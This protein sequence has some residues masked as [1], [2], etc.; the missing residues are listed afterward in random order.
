MITLDKQSDQSWLLNKLSDEAL[1]EGDLEIV[2]KS[3][4]A[5][6]GNEIRIRIFL[7]KIR[8]YPRDIIWKCDDKLFRTLMKRNGAQV[9]KVAEPKFEDK[10][11]LAFE[12]LNI[13]EDKVRII[14][15]SDDYK[16]NSK[17]DETVVLNQDITSLPTTLVRPQISKKGFQDLD[18]WVHKIEN[19]KQALQ[20]LKESKAQISKHNIEVGPVTF[21]V[22]QPRNVYLFAGAFLGLCCIVILIILFPA[23]VYT[24]EI[25]D[26]IKER[27]DTYTIDKKQFS[28]KTFNFSL[29][30]SAAASGTQKLTTERATGSVRLFNSS[31][32]PAKLPSNGQFFLISEGR[33]YAYITGTSSFPEFVIPA[34]NESSDKKFDLKIQGTEK[35]EGYNAD[36]GTSF[37]IVNTLG[38]RVC[39]SCF[40]R[41]ITPI[42]T[43][44]VTGNKLFIEE[45][46]SLLQNN[47][48]AMIDRKKVENI[49]TIRTSSIISDLNWVQNTKSSFVYSNNV[50]DVADDVILD[51]DVSSDI[52]YLTK[53]NVEREIKLSQPDIR[54]IQEITITETSNDFSDPNRE[55]VSFKAL[56]RYTIKSSLDKES[57]S[58]ILK[59]Q[60]DLENIKD[61]IMTNNPSISNISS[62]KLGLDLPL[63]PRRIDVDFVEL[64]TSI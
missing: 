11:D 39:A 21:T 2:L 49:D 51:T 17:A 56:Y 54:S 50:G 1:G 43:T 47:M 57:I 37:I 41:A 58:S 38:Q 9:A 19:T 6:L 30:V 61:E 28:K 48:Q 60:S 18:A 4:P 46:K 33:R 42:S 15:A 8:S 36:E 23:T 27:A 26:I 22:S 52:Y 53:A 3:V 45:D 44:E 62:R 13:H 59:K 16:I 31:S 63:I 64:D 20:S 24:L 29:S 35:G 10:A 55:N 14:D 7:Y 12:A 40:A 25:R 34:K 32:Q 5:F